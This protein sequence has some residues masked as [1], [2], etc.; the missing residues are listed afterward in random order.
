MKPKCL[1]D[2]L[3]SRRSSPS[4]PQPWRAP[5]I[6]VETPDING[7]G[8][9]WWRC[10]LLLL[11]LWSFWW[12]R[13]LLIWGWINV[14]GQRHS[15]G[16]SAELIWQQCRLVRGDVFTL[17]GGALSGWEGSSDRQDWWGRD[18]LSLFLP[19]RGF[20]SCHSLLLSLTLISYH[21]LYQHR[22]TTSKNLIVFLCLSHENV[23]LQFNSA[24]KTL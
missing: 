20:H 6:Y 21:R 14:G 13:H 12:R 18:I 4:P 23:Q 16:W 10:L 8:F 24:A 17:G 9:L 22:L 19:L 1:S 11:L 3:I 5:A 15:E 7:P 2:S